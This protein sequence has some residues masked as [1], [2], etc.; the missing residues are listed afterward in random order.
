VV[1]LY[2]RNKG[3]DRHIA[4]FSAVFVTIQLLE[5][6]AWLSL[7]KKDRKLNDLV[8]R[9]ILIAL[10]AQPLVNT[11]MASKGVNSWLLIIGLVGFI[12]FF[13][14]SMITVSKPGEFRTSKGPN[15]HLTWSRV[16]NGKEKFIG[17]GGFMSNFPPA[18]FIYLAGLFVPFLFIKPMS[19]GIKLAVIGALSLGIARLFSSKKEVGSFWCWAAG[20]FTLSAIFIRK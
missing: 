3:S 19:R 20:I 16:E 6:F 4:I 17:E 13:A 12:F 5:F 8:T 9:L 10:W 11:Y 1:I 2:K 18:S 7:E 15:C 14:S